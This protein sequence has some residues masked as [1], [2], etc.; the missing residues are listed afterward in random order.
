MAVIAEFLIL[1]MHEIPLLQSEIMGNSL[2]VPVEEVHVLANP[3]GGKAEFPSR[4]QSDQYLATEDRLQRI[5]PA[6]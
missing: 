3:T 5:V 6:R 2:D 1:D 4:C